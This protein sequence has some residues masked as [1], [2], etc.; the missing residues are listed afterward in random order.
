[1]NLILCLSGDARVGKVRVFV[2]FGASAFNVELQA[3]Y[4]LLVRIAMEGDLGPTHGVFLCFFFVFVEE[5][6]ESFAFWDF[7]LSVLVR[8]DIWAPL[9]LP[10]VMD[11][12][13]VP[14]VVLV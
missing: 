4:S 7:P 1:M 9:G 13:V 8:I 2:K 12:V 3:E 11:R 5:I 14:R 6:L 10:L